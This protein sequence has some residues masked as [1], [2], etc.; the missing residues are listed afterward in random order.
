VTQLGIRG[1]VTRLGIRGVWTQLDWVKEW[2]LDLLGARSW[3]STCLAQGALE[4]KV[5]N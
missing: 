2:E 4:G 1:V 3:N 5:K